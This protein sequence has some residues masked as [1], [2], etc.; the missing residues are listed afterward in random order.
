MMSKNFALLALAATTALSFSTASYADEKNPLDDVKTLKLCV[1]YSTLTSEADKAS[2]MKE[3]D[4]RGQLSVQDH[5]NFAKKQVVNGSTMCGMYMTL[6]KPMAEKGKQ[7]RPMV[8]K[9]VHV[10]PTHYYVTQ[11]GMVVE[12]YE[13]KEGELPPKLIH[14]KP[15]TQAP[16]VIYQSPGGTPMHHQ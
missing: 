7:L 2:Y 8:Y 1:D 14:E 4:R 12:K 5:D 13:R 10:Y 9:V 3:L 16:P 15:K 6:G 11:M